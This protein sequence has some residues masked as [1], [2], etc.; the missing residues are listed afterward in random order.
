MPKARA[1][2]NAIRKLLVDCEKRRY[3][4]AK[5]TDAIRHAALA[6][7]KAAI[8]KQRRL[9][10]Q[11]QSATGDRRRILEANYLAEV[12]AQQKAAKA[13][14]LACH[15]LAKLGKLEIAV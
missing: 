5:R 11:L 6:I 7:E 12:D 1:N 14:S 10:K 3:D 4:L 13:Y 15:T 9:R 8:A 2:T